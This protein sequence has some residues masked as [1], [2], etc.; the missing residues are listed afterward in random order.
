MLPPISLSRLRQTI[1]RAQRE[2]AEPDA[3]SSDVIALVV[4]WR[5]RYKLSLRDLPEKFLIRGI[6]FS[7]E[8]VR[9]WEAKF[10]P[11]LTSLRSLPFLARRMPSKNSKRTSSSRHRALASVVLP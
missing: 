3:N 10:T 5:L 6:V 9:D 2:P 7:H 4:V 8:A 1:Q 11:A